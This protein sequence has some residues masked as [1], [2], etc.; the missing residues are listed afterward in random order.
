[1]ITAYFLIGEVLRPQG[2]RG[3]AK[4]RPYARDPE[5]FKRWD[6]LYLKRGDAYE[7]VASRCSRVHDGFVYLTLGGCA[8]PEDVE[9][10]RDACLYIDR[11]HAEPLPPGMY[12]IADLLGCEAQDGEGKPVGVLTEVLQHGP[13]DVWVF[14]TPGGSTMMAPNLP[15]VFVE[16]DVANNLIRVDAARLQEVAVYED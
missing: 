15:T 5:A 3:E 1:M 16:K 8:A 13:T 14:R 9:K 4:V 6:T 11:A 12:Y 2:V 10:L 7:P